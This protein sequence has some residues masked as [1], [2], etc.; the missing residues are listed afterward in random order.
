V[1]GLIIVPL[2][3]AAPIQAAEVKPS[4]QLQFQGDYLDSPLAD[5]SHWQLAMP[6]GRFGVTVAEPLATSAL[7][8]RWQV[9]IDPLAEDDEVELR[10]HQAYLNWRKGIVS[11]WGGRLATVEQTFLVDLSSNLMSQSQKGLAVG[12]LITPSENKAIRVDLASGDAIVVT[13]QWVIDDSLPGTQW[14]GA[15]VLRTA[16]GVIAVTVR[17]VPNKS[18][19]WGNLIQWTMGNAVLSGVWLYQDELLAWD[20]SARSQTQSLQSFV[21]YRVLGE[22]EGRWSVGIHQATSESVTGFSE[23]Y[24]LPADQGWQWSTGFQM[25]F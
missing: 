2:L 17:N 24:W 18:A 14:S 15:T 4:G 7:I 16:E 1:A 22:D 8:G 9:A 10:Q 21:A 23:V 3:C 12:S 11:L 6:D 5:G 19:I 13:S 25:K 20:L